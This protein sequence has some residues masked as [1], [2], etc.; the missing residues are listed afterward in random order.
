MTRG[1]DVTSEGPKT[2]HE[3]QSRPSPHMLLP[4]N[5][6]YVFKVLIALD[7]FVASLIWRDSGVTISALTG[8]ALRQKTP[9]MWAFVLGLCILNK[10]QAN[11]CETAIAHDR[12]R[13]QE[14]LEILK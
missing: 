7:M 8:I 9:P 12:A 13:A 2:A 1:R 4:M 10:I 3:L 11:H 5:N 14:A 6:G